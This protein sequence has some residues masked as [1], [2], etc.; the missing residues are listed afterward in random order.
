[1]SNAIKMAEV[2]YGPTSTW[3]DF[4]IYTEQVDGNTLYDKGDK[5]DTII[6]KYIAPYVKIIDS[7]ELEILSTPQ[8]IYYLSDG[9]A[10]G[11]GLHN[12]ISWHF[13]TTNPEKCNTTNSLGTCHFMFVLAI[14][15]DDQY[16]KVFHYNIGKGL[17]PSLYMWDG[18]EESL[19]NDT[20]YGCKNGNGLYC[21]EII[22]RNGWK[23]PKD[24][25]RKF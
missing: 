18:N 1:M 14:K 5:Y 8:K 19:M 12:N 20:L 23:I 2:E 11:F 21:T 7:K 17:Q 4:Y 13:Y 6:N 10:F 15:P 9:T 3:T 22:R 16:G 24:Y 25:P